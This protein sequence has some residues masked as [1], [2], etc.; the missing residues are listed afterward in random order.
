MALVTEE[1]DAV[2]EGPGLREPETDP[3]VGWLKH[4]LALSDDDRVD[5]EPVLVDRA[6]P[7][8]SG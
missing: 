5:R 6:T 1:D 7:T 3:G 2:A 8:S 4:G